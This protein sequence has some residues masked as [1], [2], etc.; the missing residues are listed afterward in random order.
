MLGEKIGESKGRT[1]G[2]RVLPAGN[3]GPRL[4]VSFED[5]TKLLGIDC[6]EIGTYIAELRADGT[7]HGEGQGVV[8]GKNGESATWKGQGVGQTKKDGSASYRGCI[9]FR[10]TSEK[11]LRLN[12]TAAVFEY[13]VDANGNSKSQVWEWR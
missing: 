6:K 4:E 8:M 12:K 1:T 10:T 13:E 11:L 5:E 9:F 2:Q 3:E 7:L